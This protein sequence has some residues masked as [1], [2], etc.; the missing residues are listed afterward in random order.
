MAK[1][2][3]L[4]E[5]SW[6]DMC[7]NV[8]IVLFCLFSIFPLYWLITGS[9]K[10]SQDVVKIPPDW[11][12]KTWTLVNFQSLFA[13]TPTWRWIFNS[14]IVTVVTTCGIVLVS[15]GA[16]YAL[17]KM[18]FAGKKIIFSFVIA[19]LLV[20]MEIYVLPLYKQI[21]AFGWR[22]STTGAYLA[23]IIPNLAM[24]FGVYLMKNNFD[25]IPDAGVEAAVLDGCSRARFF[26]SIGLPLA[27]AGC[28]ALAILAG[29][30]IWNNYL[31]QLLNSIGE[32]TRYTLPVGVAMLFDQ[33]GATEDYGLKFAAAF[34]SAIPLFTIFICF[35]KLFTSG[36]SAGAVKG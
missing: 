9:F 3:K 7:S 24:P 11:W 13:T 27:K 4:R 26:F 20:P 15:S 33:T 18:R 8:F 19:A 28:G 10:F 17:S 31:W 6:F 36:V 23:M 12:P 35:Q 21:V 32:K 25:T 1:K 2:N 34:V 30:R 14:V 5:R 22:G 16:G 29:I